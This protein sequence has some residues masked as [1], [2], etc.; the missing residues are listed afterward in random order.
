MDVFGD[1]AAVVGAK[2]AGEALDGATAG[3]AKCARN[4]ASA[5]VADAPA[6]RARVEQPDTHT[7]A[8]RAYWRSARAT[9]VARCMHDLMRLLAA[10]CG[11]GHSAELAMRVN[12][13]GMQRPVW[14]DTAMTSLLDSGVDDITIGG[15]FRVREVCDSRDARLAKELA[16]PVRP[17]ARA[18]TWMALSTSDL[19]VAA[20]PLRF[21]IDADVYDQRLCCGSRKQVCDTCA[22][23][24]D[25]AMRVIERVLRYLAL[26][27]LDASMLVWVFSGRRG[28]HGWLLDPRGFVAGGTPPPVAGGGK[29]RSLHDLVSSNMHIFTKVGTDKHVLDGVSRPLAPVLAHA[30]GDPA[31]P[32][33][34]WAAGPALARAHRWLSRAD[35]REAT[36]G[37]I[38]CAEARADARGLLERALDAGEAD[39]G[40]LWASLLARLETYERQRVA[41]GALFPRIDVGVSRTPS[42]LVKAPFS[43]HVEEAGLALPLLPGQPF[44]PSRL[45]TVHTPHLAQALAPY[46]EHFAERLSA[47]AALGGIALGPSRYAPP[48]PVPAP[49][50]AAADALEAALAGMD[51]LTI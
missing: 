32:D 1:E 21:D 14:I 36:L 44:V 48:A 29:L 34:V 25:L 33:S 9:G 42:H 8:R 18:K 31:A 4:A 43:T 39:D 20:S 13:L 17:G 7:V 15:V 22:P 46:V 49:T 30:L 38:E 19:R 41:L 6:R 3:A 23:L 2:R 50:P 24:L 11:T 35:A 40:V 12:G 10:P 5:S 27:N 47:A 26:P 16:K 28:V 45:P 51:C 37:H